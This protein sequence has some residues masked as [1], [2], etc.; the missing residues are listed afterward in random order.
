MVEMTYKLARR[1]VIGLVGGSVVLLG[2]IMLVTPGPAIVV[3]P[4]GLGILSLEFAFARRWLKKLRRSISQNSA[5][6]RAQ[7]A[8]NH[9]DQV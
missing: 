8:E 1:V 6:E 2:V 3:I 9:R 4:A 7:R 5:R